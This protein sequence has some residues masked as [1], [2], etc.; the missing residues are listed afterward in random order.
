MG[1]AGLQ[2]YTHLLEARGDPGED[3]A[4]LIPPYPGRRAGLGWGPRWH[5]RGRFRASYGAR[6]GQPPRKRGRPPHS[7]TPEAALR[8]D[9]DLQPRR[10]TENLGTTN[11]ANR[12]R[13][14]RPVAAS[15]TSRARSPAQSALAAQRAPRR[16]SV[17]GKCSSQGR[18]LRPES[19][20]EAAAGR[21][22]LPPRAVNSA[23]RHR[24]TR[25]H[26]KGDPLSTVQKC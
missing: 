21:G 13:Q 22:A 16:A 25:S 26:T 1:L 2:S 9:S 18:A 10:S 20:A 6:G 8:R 12:H 11:R 14:L 3:S 23:H 5:R 7:R 15:L 19:S 24:N 4:L 17:P